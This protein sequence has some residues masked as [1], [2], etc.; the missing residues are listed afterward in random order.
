MSIK[1]HLMVLES[2]DIWKINFETSEISDISLHV[3]KR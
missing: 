2:P 3:K 1:G